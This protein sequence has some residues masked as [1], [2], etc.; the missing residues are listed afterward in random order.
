MITDQNFERRDRFKRTSQR[1]ILPAGVKGLGIG[2]I[3]LER[4]TNSA[5]ATIGNNVQVL[6]THTVSQKN[7]AKMFAVPDISIYLGSVATN[8]QLPGGSS[9]DESQ[10]QVI[11]PWNDWGTT[12]NQN[13]KT[14]VYVRNISAGSTTVLFRIKSRFFTNRQDATSASA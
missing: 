4:D 5:S 6:L 13:S 7:N 12:D 9:V 1:D 8:N 11:G 14:K 10:W 2:E 3:I